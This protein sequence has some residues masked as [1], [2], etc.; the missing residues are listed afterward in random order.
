MK[1]SG[2]A[3]FF[4]LLL[5]YAAASSAQTS[6]TYQGRLDSSGQ[7]F[8][9]TVGMDFRLYDEESDGLPIATQLGNSVQIDQ[10]LFQVELDFGTQD[11]SGQLWLEITVNGQVL[12]PRQAIS[13]TPF[14]IQ[15]GQAQV[16]ASVE[17]VTVVEDGPSINAGS[18]GVSSID[19]PTSHPVA[20]S[21]G[22]DLVNVLTMAVTSAAPRI[23]GTRL[24]GS[25]PGTYINEPDGC[26]FSARNDGSGNQNPGFRASATCRRE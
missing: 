2:L 7:P 9:G 12:S 21:C 23:S 26:Q 22:I 24:F 20:V 4:A 10:G 5:F 17:F 25:A 15:A 8:S 19:C 6:F 14:A 16:A 11:Y 3:L 1:S 18:F 13:K